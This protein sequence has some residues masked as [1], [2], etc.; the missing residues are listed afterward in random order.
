MSARDHRRCRVVL[1]CTV[2]GD[3]VPAVVD[4][5]RRVEHAHLRDGRV[6]RDDVLVVHTQVRAK[7]ATKGFG[8]SDAIPFRLAV[9]FLRPVRLRADAVLMPPLHRTA[10]TRTLVALARPFVVASRHF[11]EH[12]RAHL[13]SIRDDLSRPQ[14]IVDD[15]RETES[16]ARAF[17]A[18][19]ENR[20]A[21]FQIVRERTFGRHFNQRRFEHSVS[22]V[23]RIGSGVKPPPHWS[24]SSTSGLRRSSLR[25]GVVLSTARIRVARPSRSSPCNV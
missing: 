7:R 22:E 14:E 2:C 18:L 20:H 25:H 21:C 19:V 11:V 3:T 8:K 15:G 12:P 6:H 23:E 17:A 4:G 24:G 13:A 9:F 16:G 1:N 10:C 5:R